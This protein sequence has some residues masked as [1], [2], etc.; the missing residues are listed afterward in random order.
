MQRRRGWGGVGRVFSAG[1]AALRETNSSASNQSVRKEHVAADD[2]DSG[3][4]G[5]QAH[6]EKSE[7]NTFLSTSRSPSATWSA[8][9]CRRPYSGSCTVFVHDRIREAMWRLQHLLNDMI[10]LH[11]CHAL[12][13]R[14]FDR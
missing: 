6:A 7:R 14:G 1:L 12:T 11:G 8:S 10:E 2:A 9:R 4:I 5:M 13:L 3:S